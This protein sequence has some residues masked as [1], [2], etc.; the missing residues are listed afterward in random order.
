M[1]S[2][3]FI[4][5]TLKKELSK[6]RYQHTIRVAYTAMC[7]AMR[8]EED[9]ERAQLAGLLHD[10]AKCIPN[11]EKLKECKRKHIELSKEELEYP[12]LIHAKLGSVLACDMYEVDDLEIISA[13]AKHTTGAPDMT[14]LEK[15]IYVADYI[16]PGRYKAE[17]LKELRSVA[18][19]DIDQ[20]VYMI[21]RDTL[22]Y[23]DKKGGT[24]DSMTK[25]A[26]DFYKKLCENK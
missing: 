18:F 13:I 24:V 10:C 17:N 23:L 7:L 19:Q 16:E 8:Y 25:E 2:L 22:G 3:K 4:K 11:D 9:L 21:M 14:M 1:K 5:H 26:Y 6:D 20:C 15:I 12:E